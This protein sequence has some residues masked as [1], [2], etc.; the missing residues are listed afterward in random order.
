MSFLKKL[1]ELFRQP[2]EKAKQEVKRAPVEK[3]S[4][5]IL[6]KSFLQ[7]KFSKPAVT[8]TTYTDSE[9][10]Y[11]AIN[12]ISTSVSKIPIRL[13]RGERNGNKTE[14][15]E[16]IIFFCKVLASEL[17]PLKASIGP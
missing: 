13:Y 5:M 4:S 10:I 17:I 2:Q 3:K 12:V 9:W 15:I 1:G 8:T 6:E 14:I 7:R 11:A 16:G